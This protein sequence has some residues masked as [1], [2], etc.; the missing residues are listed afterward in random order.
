MS[1][2]LLLVSNNNNNKGDLFSYM[3]Y[4]NIIFWLRVKGDGES[5]STKKQNKTKQLKDVGR[6]EKSV[7]SP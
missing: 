7:S 5:L 3:N 6:L 1:I 4:K 2:R